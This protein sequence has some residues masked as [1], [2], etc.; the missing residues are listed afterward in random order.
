MQD[1]NTPPAAIALP[2]N[3]KASAS[4]VFGII[5]FV[6]QF[7]AVGFIPG[8]AAIIIGYKARSEIRASHGGQ[9]GDGKAKAAVILGWVSIAVSVLTFCAA[10]AA[11][12]VY[13][14]TCGGAPVC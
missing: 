14:F 12:L 1:P 10:I 13:A 3:G 2:V 5:A 4:L 11:W 6:L 7:V 8:I 9:A